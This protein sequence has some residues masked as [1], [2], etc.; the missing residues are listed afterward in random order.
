MHSHK[1]VLQC[2]TATFWGALLLA[3]FAAPTVS[4]A[5]HFDYLVEQDANGRLVTGANDFD[6]GNTLALPVRVFYRDLDETFFGSDPGYSAV[7]PANVPDGYFALPPATSLYFDMLA[8]SVGGQSVSNLWYWNGQG[9]V[10]FQPSLGEKFTLS[11]G[12]TSTSVDG[13]AIGVTG[14][15]LQDTSATGSAHRHPSYQLTATTGVTPAEGIYL[16]AQQ[17]RMPGLANS[18]PY[19]TLFVTDAISD[20]TYVTA[21][22]WAKADL[23]VPGD[24]NNDGRVDIQ[25]ITLVANHWLQAQPPADNKYLPIGDANYDGRV[26]IQDITLIANHWLQ[27]ADA[28]G[29]AATP[30]PEPATAALAA[31]GVAIAATRARLTGARRFRIRPIRIA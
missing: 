26:D 19:Y 1:F 21:Q 31:I 13:A 7:S 16:I 24:V 29:A 30:A 10:N 27:T 11:V 4:L 25:D 14:I 8:V 20:T 2:Q 23:T 28:G 9:D 15:K 5:L 12:N 18:I 22:N 3:I 17:V 6:N